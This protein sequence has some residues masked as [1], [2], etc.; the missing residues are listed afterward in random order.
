MPIDLS[1]LRASTAAADSASDVF[2]SVTTKRAG[3]IKGECATDGHTGDIGVSAWSWGVAANTAFGSTARTARR[4]YKHLVFA[5]AIDSASTGLL[6]ALVG[7]DEV[8]EAKLTMRKAGGDAVDYF[9]MTL[10]D[11]RVI[12][13][14]VDVAPDGRPIERV[15]IAFNKIDIDYKQQQSA[16]LGSGSFSFNDEVMAVS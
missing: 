10:S 7:N 11:A 8:K 5:K 14:D 4:A 16:G 3:K 6:S 12:A 1:G 15:S 2:L 13:V 9:T